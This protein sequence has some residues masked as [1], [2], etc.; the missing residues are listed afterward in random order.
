MG[1]CYTFT[2]QSLENGLCIFQ[3]VGNILLVIT[4]SKSNRTQILR[5]KKNRK[6]ESDLL[7]STIYSY[8]PF[9]SILS[10]IFLDPPFQ[11]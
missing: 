11:S 4:C 5:L 10:L 8:V 6:M 1:K 2:Y 9:A 7:C 3:A